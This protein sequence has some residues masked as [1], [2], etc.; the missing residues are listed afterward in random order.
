MTCLLGRNGP[1]EF[2]VITPRHGLLLRGSE[3]KHVGAG[4]KPVEV[5]GKRVEDREGVG[6][7]A[8]GLGEVREVR[9][10]SGRPWE[11]VEEAG[12]HGK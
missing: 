5:V 3:R 2:R 1:W 6:R 4:G 12:R 8:G 10:R 11:S 9:K 7:G